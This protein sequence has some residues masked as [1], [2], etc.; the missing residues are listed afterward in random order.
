M[1]SERRYFMSDA[2]LRADGVEIHLEPAE[3]I[4][5]DAR[6]MLAEAFWGKK[7]RAYRIAREAWH[8]LRDEQPDDGSRRAWDDPLRAR[9]EH[10]DREWRN[11]A[12]EI[13]AMR[14]LI[15]EWIAKGEA[16]RANRAMQIAAD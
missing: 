11:Q 13:L 14:R 15:P 8:A 9:C 7:A 2:E 3:Q 5:E 4:V 16:H 10:A 6:S 12:S 1:M